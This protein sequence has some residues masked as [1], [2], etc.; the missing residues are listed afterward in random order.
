MSSGPAGAEGMSSRGPGAEDVPLLP[1]PTP[2]AD[3]GFAVGK[4]EEKGCPQES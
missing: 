3:R 2:V 1:R 4:Y